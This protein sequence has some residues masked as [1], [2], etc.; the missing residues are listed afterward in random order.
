MP[1]K[2]IA[3]RECDLLQREIPLPEGAVAACVRCGAVLY[4]NPAG[5]LNRTLALLIAAAIL[6]VLANAFPVVGLEHRGSY[7]ETT[8]F[9]AVEALWNEEMH[10]VAALVLF[11]TILAPAIELLML[12]FVLASVR[13]TMRRSLAAP[14]RLALA[15]RP[16]SMIEVFMLGVLVATVK[17]SHSATIIPGMALWCYA[18]L[19]LLLAAAMASL[20]THGLWTRLAEP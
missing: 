7:R 17:L 1:V 12:I 11:T 2:L 16:W 18:V 9:G 6:F 4:R 10:L 14:L 19:I 13:S 15:V 5:G 3:C 8:L 20:D